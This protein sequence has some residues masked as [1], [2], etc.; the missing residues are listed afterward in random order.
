M[1]I[2]SVAAAAAAGV[3]AFSAAGA[4]TA[5]TFVNAN[6]TASIDLF[7]Y[8]KDLDVFVPSLTAN[9]DFTLISKSADGKSWN[10]SYDADNTST[11]ATARLVTFAFSVDPNF[12]ASGGVGGT[13]GDFT[14]IKASALEGF[15]IELCFRAGPSCNGG[16]GDGI[17]SADA[18]STGLF[19]LNFASAP[20]SGVTFDLFAGK[21]QSTS[22]N[23]GGSL[24]AKECPVGER[25]GGGGNAVPEPSSWALMILGFGSAGAMLR[26]RRMVAA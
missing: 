24:F 8:D 20:T 15:D 22:Y 21:F 5:A 25:C 14:A 17:T 2:L 18:N 12:K 16:A 11:D 26:R 7:G 13:T 10:F 9:L 19:T 23:N 4:A 6:D 1:K 3:L